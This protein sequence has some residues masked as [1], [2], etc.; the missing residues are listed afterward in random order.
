LQ[1]DSGVTIDEETKELTHIG[2]NGGIFL[3]AWI[4]WLNSQRKSTQPRNT[5][6]CCLSRSALIAEMTIESTCYTLWSMYAS[7]LPVPFFSILVYCSE[8]QALGLHRG[9]PTALH[10]ANVPQQRDGWGYRLL[11]EGLPGMFFRHDRLE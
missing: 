10:H 3:C 2:K 7:K 5:L 6:W 8:S 4:N 9:P 1:S 11:E